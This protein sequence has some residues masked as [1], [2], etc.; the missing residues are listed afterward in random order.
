MLWL[1]AST[2]KSNQKHTSNISITWTPK[3]MPM[4]FS[5]PMPMMQLLHIRSKMTE[6]P[7]ATVKAKAKATAIQTLAII[8]F[9]LILAGRQGGQRKEGFEVPLK[10]V[11][12]LEKNQFFAVGAA[13]KRHT[14]GVRVERL[15]RNTI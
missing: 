7:K 8:F 15:S 13:T 11:I 9:L 5:L 6:T 4:Q 10:A 3:H 12:V 14:Q 2:T 1:L